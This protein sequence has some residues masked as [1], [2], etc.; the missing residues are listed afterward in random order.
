MSLVYTVYTSNSCISSVT[1]VDVLPPVVFTI[2]LLLV[3]F[4]CLG[5]GAHDLVGVQGILVVF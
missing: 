5:G 3:S 4:S 1:T 2:L